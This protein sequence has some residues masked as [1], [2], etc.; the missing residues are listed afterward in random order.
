VLTSKEAMRAYSYDGA[1]SWIHEPDVVSF[2]TSTREIS[3]IMKIADT[4]KIPVTPRGRGIN[5]SGG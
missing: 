3:E 2:P 5:V 1:R 4:K